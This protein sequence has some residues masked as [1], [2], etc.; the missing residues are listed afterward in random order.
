MRDRSLTSPWPQFINFERLDDAVSA[1]KALNGREILGTE[2]GSVRIGFAKVPT[3]NLNSPFGS[4][5]PPLNGIG[6]LP[7]TYNALN[8]IAGAS[9]VPL[10]R[11]LGGEGGLQDYRSNLVVGLVTNSQ[12]ASAHAL[13]ATA[14][15]AQANGQAFDGAEPLPETV[16]ATVSEMQLLMRELG[17]ESREVEAHVQAV[18][19]ESSLW[20]GLC[21]FTD[22][23]CSQ[24]LARL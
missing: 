1:R 8:Q 18:A 23:R 21:A 6:S 11:H 13:Q 9:A 15:G 7:G 5:S 22:V 2:V 24:L 16:L 3:K 4:D 19:G 17:G 20:I 12:Y 14:G 10:D